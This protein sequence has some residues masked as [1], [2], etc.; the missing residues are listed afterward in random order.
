[1][2]GTEMGEYAVGAYLKLVE[3]CDVVDYNVRLPGG[4]LAGL[5]ELDVVGFRF[6]DGTAFLCEVT[7]HIL[8]VV[9]GSG[10]DDTLAKIHAKFDYQ[11]EYAAKQLERFPR[12]VYQFWAPYVPKGKTLASL[13]EIAG[14]EL[15]VN[16]EYKRRVKALDK[17]AAT[18]RQDTGNPF[19]RVLQIL[20]ALRD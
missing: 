15:I 14:L 8:G 16:G 11:M 19:F 4:G 7:T 12:R 13:G 2:S 9:Y 3:N 10:N 17:L 5:R 18:K 20:G 6:R 1:M